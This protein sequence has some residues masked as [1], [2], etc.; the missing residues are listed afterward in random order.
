MS[1]D[2]I[3]L[4]FADAT[5][6]DAARIAGLQ[7]AAAGAL[8]AQFGDGHWASLVTEQ[9]VRQSLDRSRVRVGRIS[10]KIVTVL[11]LAP[12]KP[13]AID[14]AYFTPVNRPLYL[15][16][17]AVDVTLQRRGLGRQALADAERIARAWEAESIRLDA[18]DA[19]AGAGAFYLTCGYA[20][21]GRVSYKGNP[22]VYFELV[23]H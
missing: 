5:E 21:R 17:M 12:R 19:D 14:V 9:G 16:G 7:N 22:L 18:Y 11:R 20:E 10:K 4:R 13:W 3:R 8:V 2:T 6:E 15:T 23:L 1:R